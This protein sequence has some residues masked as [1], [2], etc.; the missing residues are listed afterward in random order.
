M[1]LSTN[2]IVAVTKD[3]VTFRYRDGTTGQPRRCTLPAEEFIRRFL[4]H[5]VPKGFVKVRYFGL[6]SPG[7]RTVLALLRHLLILAAPA[8]P[9][10]AVS[11]PMAAPVG[12]VQPVRCP[13]CGAPMHLIHSLAPTARSPPR[14]AAGA[15][16]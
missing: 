1:A 4:P 11:A 16:V 13:V 6:F 14:P 3:Q 8:P 7:N 12:A 2:R 10:C 9:A 15:C 5:V